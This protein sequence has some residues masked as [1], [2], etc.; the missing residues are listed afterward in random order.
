MHTQGWCDCQTFHVADDPVL[1]GR[2]TPREPVE[3]GVSVASLIGER[4]PITGKIK[5]H[6]LTLEQI[7]MLVFNDGSAAWNEFNDVE[8]RKFQEYLHEAAVVGTLIGG[9]ILVALWISHPLLAI[10]VTLI[11]LALL[12]TWLDI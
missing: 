9:V 12:K 8:K 5:E 1:T 2:V 6:N 7:K 10:P 11:V 4:D 3:L